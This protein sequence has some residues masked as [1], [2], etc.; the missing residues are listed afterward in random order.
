V[1]GAGGFTRPIAL[2]RFHPE[3]CDSREF[4]T[5]LVASASTWAERPHPN[6]EQVHDLA[7]DG[8]DYFLVTEWIEG[9]SVRRF[10]DAHLRQGTSVPWSL[11]VGAAIEVLAALEDLHRRGRAHGGVGARTVRIASAGTAKLCGL[12]LVDALASAGA[13][14]VEL[15][16]R[17]LL[18]P[19]PERTSAPTVAGDVFAVGALVIGAL[20]G[21]PDAPE[22][23]DTLLS[24]DPPD[25]PAARPDVP[26]GIVAVV[27]RSL[28]LDPAERF[29]GAA[30]MARV[31][32]ELL[33]ADS[34]AGEARGLAAAVA[35]AQAV[36]SPPPRG[37]RPET[38]M[39]VDVDELE[40]LPPLTALSSLLADRR[41]AAPP[42]EG[43][44]PPGLSP[45]NT[46][47]LDADELRRLTVPD[48]ED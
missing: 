33:R 14:R 16:T 20:L 47:H 26:Q 35:G 34:A 18:L 48:D 4:I 36:L 37:I 46:E 10:V 1:V 22:F 41:A 5:S 2:K 3:L 7:S 27:E 15:E 40:E 32:S 28:R 42:R 8:H 24:G 9:L 38:T 11:L 21:E 31:L 19:V 30:S 6:A 13:T 43:P 45:Q 23:H 44:W 12:G 39:Q 29:D 17:G 25:L